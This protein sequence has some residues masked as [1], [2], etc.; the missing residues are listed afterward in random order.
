M[1]AEIVFAHGYSL[2][3]AGCNGRPGNLFWIY[4]IESRH[5]VKEIS[6]LR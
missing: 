5:G 2:A 6:A 1:F 3:M 4:C